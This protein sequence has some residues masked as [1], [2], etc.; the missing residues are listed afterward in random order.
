MDAKNGLTKVLTVANFGV[1]PR[2]TIIEFICESLSEL[3]T[4]P[5]KNLDNGVGDLHKALANVPHAA[6]RVRLNVTKCI[7][8]HAIRLHFLDRIHCSAPLEQAGLDS[9]IY[10][11][12][13]EI[14]DHYLKFQ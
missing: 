9:L 1:K 5:T 6:N 4:L 12:V 10:E 8:L 3:A 13:E 11:D 14:R 2:D 7:L